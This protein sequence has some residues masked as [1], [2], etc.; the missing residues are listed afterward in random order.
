MSGFFV[1]NSFGTF[2]STKRAETVK[3]FAATTAN[4]TNGQGLGT[5]SAGTTFKDIWAS[6]SM[7]AE[8]FRSTKVYRSND[9]LRK[10]E[11]GSIGSADATFRTYSGNKT[12]RISIYDDD[13]R[14]P[15]KG[16]YLVGALKIKPL[17]GVRMTFDILAFKCSALLDYLKNGAGTK[18]TDKYPWGTNQE[19]AVGSTYFNSSWNTGDY[20]TV[21][22]TLDGDKGDY[23]EIDMGASASVMFGGSGKGVMSGNNFYVQTD[24][25]WY[26]GGLSPNL[27][28]SNEIRIDVRLVGVAA[29]PTPGCMDS[30]AN[31]EC[32]SC[33]T[34]QNNLCTYTTA[35]PTLVSVG[36]LEIKQGEPVVITWSNDTAK[37]TTVQVLE[38]NSV[39][40]TSADKGGS[41]PHTPTTGS[42]KYRIKTLW[43]KGSSRLSNEKTVNVV[44]PTSYI[45]CAAADIHRNV[46]G[47]EECADCKPA[48]SMID[49]DGY[50]TNCEA[51]N[52]DP[53]RAMNDDGTCGDCLSGYAEHTDGTCKKVGCMTFTDGTSASGDADLGAIHTGDYN[54]DSDAEINDSS[55]CENP[56]GVANGG[57]NG[58]TPDVD[59]ELS[60]WSDWS[61]WSTAG[62]TDGVGVGPCGT[63]T[64]TRT[65]ITDSGGNGA[66]CGA[67]E[68]TETKD[69]STGEVTTSTDDIT[70]VTPTTKPS[71]VIPIIL[72]VAG[73]GVLALLMR[74]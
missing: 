69:C 65:V 20:R 30:D 52:D 29:M 63:R 31:N 34:P 21:R 37:L 45:P 74:R 16:P 62:A 18:I 47:N 4:A 68:E 10:E 67:L 54:Y 50:C 26:G 43:A 15:N 23:I 2:D 12:D 57:G 53:Y 66:V 35:L 9:G 14:R 27:M 8:V 44:T 59:C 73:I 48:Y 49:D 33:D 38:N 70:S 36:A 6:S 58:G 71:P 24:G 61:E 42:K 28:C 41:Y 7:S 40:H 22:V 60:D 32:S 19:G 11:P 55:L 46:D 72:G 3:T 56:D 13:A 5:I 25:T 39:I 1:S 64:R 17:A 51:T